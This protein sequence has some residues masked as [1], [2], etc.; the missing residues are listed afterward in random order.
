MILAI[1]PARAGS[2]GILRKNLAQLAGKPLVQHTICAA[3]K[4][5]YIDQILLS[6][7]DLEVASLGREL[8]L[9]LSYIRPTKLSEDSTSMYDTIIHALDWYEKEYSN[10]VTEILLLQ[11]TSPLRNV[12]DIDGAIESFRSKNLVSL[13]SVNQLTSHPCECIIGG[14]VGDWSYLVE[15]PLNAVRR[16]DYEKKYFFINGAIYLCS[17]DFY[18]S[19]KTFISVGKTFLYE[20]PRERSVDI[21]TIFDLF[22][23]QSLLDQATIHQTTS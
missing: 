14:E 1:I 21:D 16:Q 19:R 12:E 5:K 10:V 17:V 20:M 18:R 15:P 22:F 8:G 3:L 23:A 6:T 4:S 9:N 11:P 7:D 2:K 13:V